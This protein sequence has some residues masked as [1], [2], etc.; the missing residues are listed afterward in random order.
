MQ[1][2]S[3]HDRVQ[4][5]RFELDRA[6]GELYRDG[7][8]VRLQEHPRQVLIALIER[9]GEVVT[10]EDLRTRLW[11]S[12][13]FVDFEHGLN[14]AVKKARQALGDSAEAPEFI[15]TLARKGYRFIGHL[16]PVDTRN[17]PVSAL[18]ADVIATS[19][20]EQR[21]SRSHRPAYWGTAAALVLAAAGAGWF[22][23]PR[24]TAPHIAVMPFSVLSE[25][26]SDSE[27]LGIGIADAITTRL[28]NTRQIAVR[29]TSAVLPL[30]DAQSNPARLASTLGVQHLLM[31]SIQTTEHGYRI[32]LQLVGADGVAVSGWVIDEQAAGLVQLQDRI[33][34]QVVERLRVRLTPPDRARLHVRYTDNPAAYD[35]YLRGRSLMVN[36]TEAKM[37]EAIGYFEQALRIDENYA[38]ARAALATACAWFSVRY[39]HEPEALAWGKR[40]DEEARRALEQDS[41]LAD[42]HFAIASAAG[43]EYGGFDWRHRSG[44]DCHGAGARPLAR[45]RT[46]RPDARLLSP[47]PLRRS[48]AGRV[49]SH[50]R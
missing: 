34:E 15:E 37:H 22:A 50:N 49:D 8:P 27:Y 7:L 20:A 18:T 19:V 14:T 6:A 46:P 24:A 28:A 41:S 36:Y 9:P 44:A 13:T 29:P 35:M 17:V 11:K 39:A 26:A 48:S 45:P 1:T 38:L 42:A 31:G 5:G 21:P 23:L 10:R 12:D 3:E 2:H 32:S 4:F 33:A 43:T 47:R 25:S 16:D 30:K 40:A